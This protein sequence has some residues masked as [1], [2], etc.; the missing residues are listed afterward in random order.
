M[1]LRTHSVAL[2]TFLDTA[3]SQG[4]NGR[5]KVREPWQR[6]GGCPTSFVNHISN[7]LHHV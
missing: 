7:P 5:T 3:V 4:S 6:E 2:G 1:L